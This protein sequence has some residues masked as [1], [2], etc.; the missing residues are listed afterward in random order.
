[1]NKLFKKLSILFLSG[2]GILIS[3][4]TAPDKEKLS[5]KADDTNIHTK[6]NK[7]DLDNRTPD[8]TII[9]H[10][11]GG[12]PDNWSN[13]YNGHKGSINGFEQDPDSLIE[14][15]RSSVDGGANLYQADPD[16][17]YSEYDNPSVV[18]GSAYSTLN[19]DRHTIIVPDYNTWSSL[20]EV[21]NGFHTIV[22]NVVDEFVN[23]KEYVPNINLVGHSMGGIVN[24][25]YAIDHPK[26]VASLISLGTPYNGSWYDN[27]FVQMIGI[28]DF[29]DQPCICG[30]CNHY[31]F[32]YCNIDERRNAW[33]EMYAENPHIKFYAFSGE[34]SVDIWDYIWDNG[35]LGKYVH[36][37]ADIIGN[38]FFDHIVFGPYFM[39]VFPGD[40]CVDVPSQRATGYNGVRN[41]HKVFTTSNAN[42]LKVSQD[43]LPVV[44][45]LEARDADFINIILSL[46]EFGNDINQNSELVDGL[47]VK[48]LSKLNDNWVFLAKNETG[49]TIEID[50]NSKLCFHSDGINWSGLGDVETTKRLAPGETVIIQ[51]SNFGTADT[52]ALSYVYDS[53]R[54]IVCANSLDTAELTMTCSSNVKNCASYLQYDMKVTLVSKYFGTWL[55][56]LTNTGSKKAFCYNSNMCFLSDAKN[57]SGLY[58]VVKT[59]ELETDESV[60]VKISEYGTATSIGVCYTSGSRRYVFSADNLS[61]NGT[62]SSYGTSVTNYTYTSNGM[63]LSILGKNGDSWLVDVTNVSNSVTYYEFNRKMCFTSDAKNWV[64]LTDINTTMPVMKNGTFTLKISE[65]ALRVQFSFRADVSFPGTLY[66]TSFSEIRR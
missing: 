42:M 27:D 17:V 16:Y 54:H 51:V 3:N 43:N 47:R 57:W 22:D 5:V 63:K 13:G 24:M 55:V 59:K 38:L 12:N 18:T 21:Y 26:N 37:A 48:L 50:Y 66:L 33:N 28:N 34:M 52:F 58:N 15:I 39:G 32:K 7:S 30:T 40:I 8:I 56:K 10:G 35:L 44:H 4:V 19:F 65:N 61:T 2:F 45:N 36:P 64:N 14:R 9:T 25:I 23:K 20:E 11:L 60:I 1:M 31:D 49:T 6:T 29:N 53:Y 46:M 41:F 62:L